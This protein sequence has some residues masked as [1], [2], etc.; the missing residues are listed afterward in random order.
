MLKNNKKILVI[1]FVLFIGCAKYKHIPE[2]KPLEPKTVYEKPQKDLVLMGYTIQ[3]GAF[4]SVYNAAKLT[5]LLRSKGLDATYFLAPDGFYKVRFGNFSEKIKAKEKA[6]FLKKSGVITEFYIVSPEDYSVAKRKKLGDNY[7]RD[8]L[9]KTA[10]S[11]IGVPYLWGGN[12]RETGF[13]C[14]S[15]SMTVYQL[16]G[17]NMPRSSA[18]QY[19]TGK[20]TEKNNL[21]KGD[22]VFFAIKNNNQVSHVGIYIGDE[23]FIHAPGSGKN[24][25]KESLNNKYYKKRY[26]GA[27]TYL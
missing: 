3:A 2:T 15:L 10:E 23:F 17:I 26:I 19:N 20:Y 24:I 18:Q 8:K 13:D 22:L 5:E 25:R 6:L 11:F 9:V 14:S 16:N 1:I 12:S 7:F 4:I 27:K 21:Q